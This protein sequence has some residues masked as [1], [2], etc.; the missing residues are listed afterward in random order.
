MTL[1][2]CRVKKEDSVG[3][4]PQKMFVNLFLMAQHAGQSTQ[5][6]IHPLLNQKQS[7]HNDVVP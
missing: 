2:P 7:K 5:N 4:G 6:D 3:A 1:G